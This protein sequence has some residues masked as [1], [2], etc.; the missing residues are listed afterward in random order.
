MARKTETAVVE[1]WSGGYL[2]TLKKPILLS[3]PFDSRQTTL[4]P[5]STPLT[6]LFTSRDVQLHAQIISDLFGTDIGCLDSRGLVGH[7]NGSAAYLK[8]QN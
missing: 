5:K 1:P 8:A 4:P 7:F 2:P 3:F 6:S